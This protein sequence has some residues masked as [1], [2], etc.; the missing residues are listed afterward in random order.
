MQCIGRALGYV[1]DVV[2]MA[3]ALNISAIVPTKKWCV[4]NA[5]R[6]VRSP[7]FFADRCKPAFQRTLYDWKKITTLQRVAIGTYRTGKLRQL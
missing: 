2:Q 4:V 5:A 1:N 6:H 7:I 3:Q